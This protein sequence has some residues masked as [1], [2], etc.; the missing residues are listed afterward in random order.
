[1]PC[2]TIQ[3][4][5]VDLPKMN[6][7]LLGRAITAIGGTRAGSATRFR[8]RGYIYDAYGGELESTDPNVGKVADELKR[9]YSGEVVKYTA[10]R[11]GWTL[12]QTAAY[13][14]EVTK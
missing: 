3:T 7:G 8:L 2:D 1:M 4:N 13:E 10:K 6:A 5:T 12:K 11:N 14:Y 9:A